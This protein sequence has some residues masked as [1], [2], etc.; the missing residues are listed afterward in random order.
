MSYIKGKYRPQM[1]TE[2]TWTAYYRM[3]LFT[4]KSNDCIE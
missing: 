2:A 4:D 1:L 3:I